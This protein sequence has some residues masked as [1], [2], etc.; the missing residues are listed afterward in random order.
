[1]CK[2]FK[3]KT[4]FIAV[5]N[6]VSSLRINKRCTMTI[7]P[8]VL[9]SPNGYIHVASIYLPRRTNIFPPDPLP[10]HPA[11]GV[12]ELPHHPPHIGRFP[13]SDDENGKSSVYRK[14]RRSFRLDG[15]KSGHYFSIFIPY[16]SCIL[17]AIDFRLCKIGI[18]IIANFTV[19]LARYSYIFKPH[20]PKLMQLNN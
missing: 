19:K 17:Y 9:H 13:S 1:M 6:R 10:P 18:S 5:K 7:F 15:T 3:G 16:I 14:R 8:R 2:T 20:Y 4:K 11:S 12:I